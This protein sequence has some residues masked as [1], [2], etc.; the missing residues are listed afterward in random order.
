M[1]K[2][3]FSE[4]NNPPALDLSPAEIDAYNNDRLTMCYL[5]EE[6]NTPREELDG[7]NRQ[8]YYD[9]NRRKDLS[10]IPPKQNIN[11]LRIVTGTTREKD[12]TLLSTLLN[13]N[14][15]PD[16][17]AFDTEDMVVAELGDNMT[18]LIKKTEEV[19]IFH[20]KRPILY[21]EMIA[22]GDVFIEDAYIEDFIDIPLDN[23]EWDPE[24]NGGSAT[25]LTFKKRIQKLN[26]GCSYEMIKSNMVYLH[27][28]TVE[29]IEDQ[30][31]VA[32]C[33][34]I[35][36]LTA[37]S[38]YGKWERWKNVPAEV[39]TIDMVEWS[40]STSVGTSR[41]PWAMFRN[42]LGFCSEVKIYYK[43][44]NRYALYVNGIPMTPW[45]L[46]FTLI[47]KSGDLPFA[48]GKLEPIPGFALSKSQPAKTKV[49]Q[50]VL[51]EV[52]TLMIEAFR[53][54]RKP[55]MGSS[56][57][58][59]YGP[60][61]F[62][63]G[64]ITPGIRANNFY[65]L[66]PDSALRLDN[67]EF[68]FYN[69][70]KTSINEKTVN[71]V[72]TG[73]GD[74]GVNT[75]GQ[76]EIMKQQQML[77]LGSAL[78]GVVNLHRRLAWLR[79]ENIIC[80]LMTPVDKQLQVTAEG[81]KEVLSYR[82]L[83][84]ETTLDTGESARKAFRFN[85]QAENP[86]VESQ[87]EEEER[88]SKQNR[89]KTRLVYID[90]EKMQAIKYNW[91]IIVN[92]TPRS[93]D[94]LSQLMFLQNVK[95]AIEIFGPES[96]NFEYLKKR[97]AI[98]MNEDFTKFFRADPVAMVNAGVGPRSSAMRKPEMKTNRDPLTLSV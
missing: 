44:Q 10:Y 6:F 2:I 58:E 64:K 55:P 41:L 1:A 8:Q 77:K 89:Q 66:L 93:N 79:I 54:K 20:K 14:L 92:P 42:K 31:I 40:A 11:D 65:S 60:D 97:Y 69:T 74:G 72:F 90:P 48:Q 88:L 18:D 12:T 19:E 38:R 94:K 73:E 59:V 51:D 32:I 86:D 7:M 15:V 16:V 87:Y 13:L 5:R 43:R 57:D 22:Q 82:K 50:E 34:I 95:Q 26:S 29:Y 80:N 61:V 98:L 91:F 37:Y 71:E 28:M 30:D 53:Q 36:W 33:R 46:P 24:R 78:D 23:V 35:P 67:S 85:S 63:A 49:D 81:L 25:A 27:D 45:N 47:R 62:S 3:N 83:S 17:T 75:L 70:I 21:R 4:H 56:T 76:A 84:V 68:S 9:S 39:N 96:L 52:T